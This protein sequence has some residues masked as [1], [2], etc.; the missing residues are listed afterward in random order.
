MSSHS[1][2]LFWWCFPSP[3]RDFSIFLIPFNS[4]HSWPTVRRISLFFYRI[5]A[6]HKSAL[7]FVLV[8][9]NI[10]F[11]PQFYFD[12]VGSVSSLLLAPLWNRSPFHLN[13]E[14][15]LPTFDRIFSTLVKSLSSDLCSSYFKLLWCD[16]LAQLIASPDLLTNLLLLST[17]SSP[18]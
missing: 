16:S 17:S 12:L 5:P 1:S 11:C 6:S 7:L 18:Q 14:L 15:S 9:S 3:W 2:L 13:V 4:T 10:H 8:P